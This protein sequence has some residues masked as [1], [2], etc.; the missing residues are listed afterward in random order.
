MKNGTGGMMSPDLRA[1]TCLGAFLD[2]FGGPDGRSSG[3]DDVI[4]TSLM[5]VYN[6]TFV[7]FSLEQSGGS[8]DSSFLLTC[9]CIHRTW[10][11]GCGLAGE[12]SPHLVGSFSP[13]YFLQ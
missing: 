3:E 6:Y 1:V 2:D 5:E 9:L 11:S 12:H 10:M 7:E 4:M 8:H 13:P